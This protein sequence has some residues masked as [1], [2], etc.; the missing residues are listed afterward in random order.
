[1]DGH[2]EWLY[3]A[4]IGEKL[5]Q[6]SKKSQFTDFKNQLS[7]PVTRKRSAEGLKRQITALADSQHWARDL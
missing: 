7:C 4:K 6:V 1:M 3:M 2:T 5:E